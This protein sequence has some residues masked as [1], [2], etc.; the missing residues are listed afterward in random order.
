MRRKEATSTRA[1][2]IRK[3]NKIKEV[4]VG[5]LKKFAKLINT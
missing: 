2:L 5:S 3:Q 1:N 4:E